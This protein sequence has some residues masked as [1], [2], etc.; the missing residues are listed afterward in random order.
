[1]SSP[2][3]LILI[4]R[5]LMGQKASSDSENC[6]YV[7]SILGFFCW[8]D[9]DWPKSINHTC[10]VGQDGE[11]KLLF[12]RQQSAYTVILPHVLLLFAFVQCLFLHALG[13]LQVV[14]VPFWCPW[15]TPLQSP[16]S[17]NK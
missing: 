6:M 11:E 13:K 17:L 8:R 1:M 5:I 4:S 9:V 16:L 14:A 12:G 7:L 15:P 10:F 2:D 3:R